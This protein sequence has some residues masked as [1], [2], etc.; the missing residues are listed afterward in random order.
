[1]AI[2]AAY[3]VPHPPILLPEVGRGEE[4]KISRTAQAY[5]EVMRRVARHRPDVLFLASPHADSYADYFHLSPGRVAHGSLEQFHAPDSRLDVTYDEA[6]VQ[7][8]ENRARA[9]GLPAGTRGRREGPLDHGTLIP[10]LFLAKTGFACPVVRIGLS[11]LSARSHYRLGQC[12]SGAA[13]ALGRRA[14][15]IASGDLSHKLKADGPYGFAPEGPA[16]DRE[17]TERFRSADFGGLLAIDERLSDAA[18]E[19]G[20]RSFQIMAGALDQKAVA[21]EVLSYEGPF[22]VGYCVAAFEVTGADATRNFDER[23]VQDRRAQREA[24][25][26]A[27]DDFVR[28][29]RLS[30]ETYVRSGRRAAVPEGL[31]PELTEARG[32]AFVS[33]HMDGRLRGCIGTISPTRANLAQEI[34]QNAVSAAVSDPRFDPVQVEELGELTY[35]VDVLAPA[36]RIDGPEMLDPKRY[37]VIVESGNRRG[38]LLPDLEGVDT[39]AQQMEI[40]R[41]KAG[42]GAQ[43]EVTLSRFEVVRHH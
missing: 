22:G 33:L 5:D 37:G 1:M 41:R 29:A 39:V 32:G 31:S 30:L 16:L 21:P 27:E 14:V 28:L 11:G 36:E 23:Y 24:H 34:M 43:E 26:A 19:C 3:A 42:I 18:A 38:L 8:I 40:A 25:R 10:L 9:Q 12:L 4:R 13:D 6:L 17:L 2:L 15:F 20:L 7:E 35:S